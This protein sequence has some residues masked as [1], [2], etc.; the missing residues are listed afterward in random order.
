RRQ[1]E[2]YG[3]AGG[4]DHWYLMAWCRLRD[5]GRTFRLDRM[6]A[7]RVTDEPAPQRELHEVA[8][9]IVSFARETRLEE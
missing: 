2:P 5:G 3:L 7:A 1:V 8:G 9:D 6:Q 4:Q